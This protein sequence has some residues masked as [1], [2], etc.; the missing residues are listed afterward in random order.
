MK[1]GANNNSNN[2]SFVYLKVANRRVGEMVQQLRT[3]DVLH[4]Y[5]ASIPST[6]MTLTTV[7]NSNFMGSDTLIQLYT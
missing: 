7:C 5:L 1:T 3:L 4:E 2:N 6:P